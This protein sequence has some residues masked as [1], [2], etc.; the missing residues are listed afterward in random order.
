MSNL[1]PL[2]DISTP[3]RSPVA[4]EDDSFS[5]SAN[6]IR[7]AEDSARKESGSTTSLNAVL[8]SPSM[9]SNLEP[10]TALFPGAHPVLN[11]F[12]SI[13]NRKDFLPVGLLP[14]PV[15]LS[16]GAGTLGGLSSNVFVKEVARLG[17]KPMIILTLIAALAVSYALN[18][19]ENRTV[20]A[21]VL[22]QVMVIFLSIHYLLDLAP[23][24]EP[25]ADLAADLENFVGIASDEPAADP[26]VGIASDEPAANQTVGSALENKDSI[27]AAASDG[28]KNAWYS[29]KKVWGCVLFVGLAVVAA[30]YYIKGLA[31]V[32]PDDMNSFT[33][34][35]SQGIENVA[36]EQIS[37]GQTVGERVDSVAFQADQLNRTSEGM[38][39]DIAAAGDIARQQLEQMTGVTQEFIHLHG[40]V[41]TINDR[42]TVLLKGIVYLVSLRWVFYR[43]RQ[44]PGS[45][46]AEAPAAGSDVVNEVMS[47]ER[48]F[49]FESTETA[50]SV[51]QTQTEATFSDVEIS[52]FTTETAA[53]A[54]GQTQTEATF[55]DSDV[56]EI[57]TPTQN[58]TTVSQ[59]QTEAAATVE[60]STQTLTFVDE[61]D[62]DR[63]VN[64]AVAE[65]GLNRVLRRW[66]NLMSVIS[67]TILSSN[68]GNGEADSADRLE[69]TGHSPVTELSSASTDQVALSDRSESPA[70]PRR[71]DGDFLRVVDNPTYL[72]TSP[73]DTGSN[74]PENPTYQPTSPLDMGR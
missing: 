74:S 73:L 31:P 10:D 5:L 62:S 22:L 24:L 70:A 4:V 3:E 63:V 23:T 42:M 67:N 19:R 44:N 13:R 58:V 55:S 40:R 48:P 50:V 72:P 27:E 52:N 37:L 25:A 65:H 26:K 59:T 60:I 53:T 16:L 6:G 30:V 28:P 8:P 34:A 57:S 43:L 20:I 47:S 9:Q 7:K 29:S 61:M 41:D 14:L 18:Y 12:K 51:G 54:V 64:P 46:L 15:I 68:D 11:L 38:L 39:L 56:V 69:S 2:T 33:T 21:K 45:A 36:S 17:D 66:R 49:S 35:V 71:L 1:S 32:S